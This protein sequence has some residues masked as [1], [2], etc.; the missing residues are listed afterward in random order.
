MYLH[1]YGVATRGA[2]GGLKEGEE[3]QRVSPQRA[4]NLVVEPAGTVGVREEAGGRVWD[5]AE[6][7]G[8]GMNGGEAAA[9]Q[10]LFRVSALVERFDR[11]RVIASHLRTCGR[12]GPARVVRVVG[13]V[14]RCEPTG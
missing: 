13:A 4:S 11:G 5:P 7:N 14:F 3:K 12:R 1:V 8:L 2:S 9:T 6:M 10:S